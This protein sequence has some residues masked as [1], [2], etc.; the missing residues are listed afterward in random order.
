[1]KEKLIQKQTPF[2]YLKFFLLFV[3]ILLSM[4]FLIR[5]VL[6]IYESKFQDSSFYVLTKER[7]TPYVVHFDTGSG[8]INMVEIKKKNF[9]AGNKMKSSLVSEVPI[10]ASVQNKDLSDIV[11]IP[12][13]LA[14]ALTP[15][16]SR[17]IDG[18][19]AVDLFKLYLFILRT[20]VSDKN[21]VFMDNGKNL[22]TV[23]QAVYDALKDSGIVN[24][25]LSVEIVNRSGENGLGTKY[26]TM[27]KNMG[28][29]VISV[30]TGT[31]IAKSVIISRSSDSKTARKIAHLL[32]FRQKN[33]TTG[34]ITD[35][36]IDIG[37]DVLNKL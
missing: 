30:T 8:E 14:H 1:M 13:I 36:T 17:D 26:A 24:E 37:Q 19:N 20:N 6:M 18:M 34:G 16:E 11:S 23:Q 15:I 35:I 33:S 4:S 2:T 21:T 5:I 7:G 3:V 28:V 10:D 12:S 29:N 27:L 32:E 22:L 25:K 31:K 9:L